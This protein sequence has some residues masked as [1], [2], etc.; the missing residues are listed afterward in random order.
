MP[1]IKQVT[2]NF[3]L[4]HNLNFKKSVFRNEEAT[5]APIK[6]TPTINLFF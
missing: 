5:F 2:A 1:R 3:F 4:L 6:N